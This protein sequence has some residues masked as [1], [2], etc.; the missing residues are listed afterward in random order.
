MTGK[1]LTPKV[2]KAARLLEGL[3]TVIVE[4]EEIKVLILLALLASGHVLLE[5]MP[6]LGK[7]MLVNV[8][9]WLISG[10]RSAR[11]QMTPDMKP[12]DI[13]GFRI[14]N[15][16]TGEFEIQPGPIVG[17]GLVLA[18]EG[19]RTT[20]KTN[21]A[22]LQAMQEGM[23]TIGSDTLSLEELFLVIMTINPIEQEGTFP[24]PE[25]QLDR[26][27]LKARMGYI[28]EGG[29]VEMLRRTMV[30][31]RNAR[32]LIEPVCTVEDI[33]AMRKQVLEIAGNA[34]DSALELI[35]RLVR[36]TRPGD[37]H[38]KDLV[39]RSGKNL[40]E[41]VYSGCSPRAEIW[42]L[43]LAA[44]LAFLNG[45][46]HISADDVKFVFPHVARHRIIM[47]QIAELDK[48]TPDHVIDIVL[49]PK[50]GV[51]LLDVGE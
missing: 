42:M 12:S 7:T 14:F 39:A 44:A 33:L 3:D 49:D 2:E 50:R 32:S 13:V 37:P 16:K 40:D 22:L 46:R 17:A 6:G 48:L 19:N 1:I 11:I 25:A 24:L 28:S 35:V 41:I 8:L 29:E 18:D 26:F 4:N 51:P 27:A 10:T 15:P 21:S 23:V 36:A 9:Q 47:Q 43:H 45:R 5:S 20:P 31:G 38:F 30:H 34:S